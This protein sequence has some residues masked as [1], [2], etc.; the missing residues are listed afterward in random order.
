M[1][2]SKAFSLIE[3]SIV[4]LIIGILIAGVT[5]GSRLVRQSNLASARAQTNNSPVPS[6]SGLVLWLESTDINNFLEAEAED[7]TNL[8]QWNDSNPQLITKNN[9]S[10]ATNNSNITYKAS[11]INGLPAVYY[12]GTISTSIVLKGSTIITPNNNF[13]V[14][15]AS[16]VA[17]N[18]SATWRSVL[19][20]GLSSGFGYAKTSSNKRDASLT[21]VIDNIDSNTITTNPE[22][23]AITYYNGTSSLFVNGTQATLTPST[24]T[25]ITPT[26]GLNIGANSTGSTPWFGSIGEIIIYDHLLKTSER[27]LVEQYL[28]KKWE[29]AVAP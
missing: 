29:I 11:A 17:E 7:G 3:L 5:Q 20:N 6:I 21:N 24:G 22:I 26:G 15:V 2:K 19:A 9:V 1:K 4:V 27:K 16:Q 13:T 28:S 8:T 25:M 18:N 14:F 23:V 10:R 12:N